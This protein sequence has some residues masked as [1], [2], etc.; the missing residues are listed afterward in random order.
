MKQNASQLTDKVLSAEPKAIMV[1]LNFSSKRIRSRENFRDNKM[2]WLSRKV[3]VGETDLDRVFRRV[4][5]TF[6]NK[7]HLSRVASKIFEDKNLPNL[8]DIKLINYRGPRG[9][10]PSFAFSDILVVNFFSF[11]CSIIF[12]FFDTCTIL[13]F[14]L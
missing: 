7:T 5:P 12:C 10:F 9:T 6:E 2:H 8:K 4:N 14:V 11:L 1:S 3:V 13:L